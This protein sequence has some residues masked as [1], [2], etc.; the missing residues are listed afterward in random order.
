MHA[1]TYSNQLLIQRTQ[2][3]TLV[4][5]V[6]LQIQ[7]PFLPF[8]RGRRLLW[9]IVLLLVLFRSSSAS[10]EKCPNMLI[11]LDRSGSMAGWKWQT[12]I[13]S[14]HQMIPPR[15]SIMRFGLMIFPSFFGGECAGG[16]LKVNCDFYTDQAI[17]EALSHLGSPGGFT[18]T[19]E[20]LE[21]ASQLP[22]INDSSR[23]RFII[24]LTDGDPTCPDSKDLDHNLNLTVE[25][26]ESIKAKGVQTFVIGFGQDVSPHRLDRMAQAGGTA[27][28]NSTCADP[29]NPSLRIPC[30]Y[31]DA[32]DSASLNETFDAIASAAQGELIS[33]SCDDSCYGIGGCPESERCVQKIVYYNSGKI[34]LNLGQCVEDP[35]ASIT[36]NSDN[37]YCYEG[38]C[39][40]ACTEPCPRSFVCQDGQ[41]VQDLCAEPTACPCSSTC[42]NHLICLD[43]AC[44]DDPCRF[45]SCP[46]S[47]PYCNRG[48]CYASA[49]S[50]IPNSKDNTSSQASSSNETNGGCSAAPREILFWPLAWII[51]AFARK[52]LHKNSAT[53]KLNS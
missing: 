11:L 2:L 35:C 34:A 10:A 25:N 32:R 18:P 40:R 49:T 31:Y 5:T 33:N 26:I 21:Q 52:S 30:N 24:L 42:P 43:G 9:T 51:Y 8:F 50:V 39:V 47:A 4:K 12:A 1:N 29:I 22:E 15:E 13:D 46:T 19:A 16:E 44:V 38:E 14:I 6:T 45:V 27:R 53:R 3:S 36:C 7:Q 23:K 41:C 37:Q 48:G 20:V 28:Q 17:H